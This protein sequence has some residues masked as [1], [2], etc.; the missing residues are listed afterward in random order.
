MSIWGELS[1]EAAQQLVNQV[2]VQRP[3]V[4]KNVVVTEGRKHIGKRGKVFWHGLDKYSHA[5]RYGG[6]ATL[7]LRQ[8]EGRYGFRIGIE[9]ENGERFF[10][11]ADHVHVE[12]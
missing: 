6:D 8:V 5:F 1:H 7:A 12:I 9:S 10:I 2:A 3:S 4:G 11:N